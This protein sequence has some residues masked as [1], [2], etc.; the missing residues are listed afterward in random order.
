VFFLFS[1]FYF[2]HIEILEA[3]NPKFSKIIQICSRKGKKFQKIPN[4]FAEKFARKKTT[5]ANLV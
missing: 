4:F 1:F 5:G 2:F 3:F